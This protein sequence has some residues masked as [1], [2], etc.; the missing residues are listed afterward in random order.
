MLETFST[1]SSNLDQ[2]GCTEAL[3]FSSLPLI[4]LQFFFLCKSEKTFIFQVLIFSTFLYVGLPN[5]LN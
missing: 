1:A 4:L 2:Q 5:L 3:H